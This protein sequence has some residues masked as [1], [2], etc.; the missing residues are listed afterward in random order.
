MRSFLSPRC[1]P[2]STTEIIVKGRAPALPMMV[3]PSVWD[4]PATQS[5]CINF[6]PSLENYQA[7]SVKVP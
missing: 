7:I 6:T 4:V 1:V 2:L 3:A 5:M